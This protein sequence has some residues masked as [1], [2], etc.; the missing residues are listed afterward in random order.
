[1]KKL[2]IKRRELEKIG[3]TGDDLISLV[4][5][6]IQRNYKHAKKESMLNIL[7]DIKDDPSKY[8]DDKILK[9]LAQKLAEPADSGKKETKQCEKVP[10]DLAPAASEYIIYGSEYIEGE[11]IRQMETAMRL[12]VTRAG[13]LMADAH[14]GYGLPIGGV[15]A[16]EN[17][18]IPY[19]VGMDIGCRMSLS[20]FDLPGKMIKNKSN[21]LKK[22]LLENT[23]FGKDEF[24]ERTEH[25]VLDHKSFYEIPFLKKNKDKA[26][27]QLGT[28]GSGNHFVDIGFLEVGA[29]ND[30]NLV[31]GEYLAILSHSG[32]RNFGA[33]IARHYTRIAKDK[34]GLPKGAQNLSW[35]NL[36]EEEGIEYWLAM[37]LA[38]EYS[39]AN[40][41]VIHY[42]LAS[43][44]KETPLLRVE[45]HHNF[46][47]K[48]KLDD[49]TS[50]IVH[51]KGATPAARGTL[52]IIP[53]S[54]TTPAFLVRGKGN[55][56]SLN[57]AS[58]GAG[59]KMSRAA[60]KQVYTPK[61]LQY[62]L[63]KS[64]V[65]LL[66]GGLDESPGAYKDI[67]Q[68]MAKQRDLVDV[69]AVFYP[70]IVRMC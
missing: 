46:A 44:L 68:V 6:I 12:P 30:L 29:E 58:H 55:A 32:S 61:K 54:M 40:H 63:E 65:E 38:G 1:M 66:G 31:P 13:A 19:G 5:N 36:D 9:P 57:S 60:A 18:I 27:N 23:R 33:E 17:A 67:N 7:M 11:A 43:A 34:C 15:L 39:A 59:R 8:L 64:G 24:H 14:T 22:I 35:L 41:Q 53:G 2:K 21:T 25:P 51:R 45:N 49:G 42:K 47:W 52:G 56:L 10:Y 4:I 20:V 37:S 48:E 69:L 3:F 62:E 26:W 16:T 70:K 28:S 50:V